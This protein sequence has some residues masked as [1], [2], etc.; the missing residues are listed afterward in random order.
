MWSIWGILLKFGVKRA[1][2][3]IWGKKMCQKWMKTGSK[4]RNPVRGP[5]VPDP[6]PDHPACRPVWL[7]SGCRPV[8]DPVSRNFARKW[9]GA[10]C[11]WTWQRKIERVLQLGS[12]GAVQGLVAGD[13]GGLESGAEQVVWARLLRTRMELSQGSSARASGGAIDDGLMARDL[14]MLL[15]GREFEAQQGVLGARGLGEVAW[16]LGT[17][18]GRPGGWR[19]LCSG[20]SSAQGWRRAREED[21]AGVGG[22]GRP[23]VE[24]G[25]ARGWSSACARC[26]ERQWRWG[27]ASVAFWRSWQRGQR[28]SEVSEWMERRRW[29]RRACGSGEQ[30]EKQARTRLVLFCS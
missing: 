11:A 4:L 9:S 12:Q 6:G 24:S 5:V 26:D 30:E 18:T 8:W 7:R 10:W 14:A 16:W 3:K 25:Q 1:L 23:E 22:A 29:S 13:G 28:C 19:L 27:S 15:D 20:G 17:G 2:V 21:A